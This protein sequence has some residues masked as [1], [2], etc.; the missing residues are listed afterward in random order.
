MK[1]FIGLLVL[2]FAMSFSVNAQ[3]DYDTT[4]P[5]ITNVTASPSIVD[6]SESSQI[7]TITATGT[8]DLS[9]IQSLSGFFRAPT[10]E[11][12]L[13]IYLYPETL[14]NGDIVYVGEIEVPYASSFSTAVEPGIWTFDNCTVYDNANNSIDCL[15]QDS[16]QPSFEVTYITFVLGCT[17]TT[18]FNYNAEA[19][20]DDASCVYPLTPISQNNIHSAV[21]EWVANESLAESTYGHI[22]DWDVSSVTNMNQLFT[23]LTSFNGDFSNASSFNGDISSWD[24]SS[25]TNMEYMFYIAESFNN[26]IS[27]WD[28]SSVTNMEYM[29][30]D[31]TNFNGDIS[32]WDVSSV[33]NM[34]YLFSNAISFNQDISSWNVSGL[35]SMLG[36]FNDATDFNQDLSGWDVS[37]IT[38]MN[39]MFTGAK[40]FN[41]D[42][43][44]WDVSS[45]TNMEYMFF[46]AES[47]NQDISSWNGNSDLHVTLM[48]GILTSTGLSEENKCL[49]NTSFSAL[50]SWPY[51]WSGFC[52][53]GCTNPTASNYNAN[54]NTDDASCNIPLDLPEGW[55]M[56]GYTCMESVDA[57]VG[58]SSISDKIEIVKDE[59]GLAYL[60]SWGFNAMGSLHFSEGY[61]IKMI[62]EVTNYQFCEPEY[63]YIFQT[64]DM[65]DIQ[66]SNSSS[67]NGWFRQTSIEC[68]C[69]YEWADN[70]NPS[71][72]A[73]DGSCLFP[74]CTYNWADNYSPF[75]TVNDGSCFLNG[76][77]QA[78][79]DAAFNEGVASVTECGI[80]NGLS[81]N[82]GCGCGNPQAQA[83][84]DCDGNEIVPLQ[85]GDQHAGGIVFQ[86]NEDGTGLVYNDSFIGVDP[87][88]WAWNDAMDAAESATS[89]GYDDWYLPNAP[90]LQL[91]GIVGFPD[92]HNFWSSSEYDSNHAWGVDPNDGNSYYSD[93]DNKGMVRI[94]RA[95]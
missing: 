2:V 72:N 17:D 52:I 33:T 78:D 31:A 64:C 42:I 36:M 44:S 1:N 94:I 56:F 87:Y 22:S 50:D 58:F 77:S 41:G 61:Q 37:N 67:S 70:Y 32:S 12:V 16:Y 38:N 81:I 48:E 26:D 80:L 8:D 74:G 84:Y 39:Q 19:N 88:I 69:T 21:A 83:G 63:V 27:S 75:A 35:T 24:V 73:E 25:V 28:V 9:G 20:T 3:Q 40:S 79:L 53:E 92:P 29:F 23:G 45:V 82:L 66:Y 14:E 71:A 47:F 6:V 95:F 85:I 90:E 65:Y 57:M 91:T 68:G 15:N 34:E 93:K 7:V 54:A 30:N 62:E 13:W 46:L 49:I 86:I 55:S 10:S 43:S 51:D 5:V 18:A 76:I 89:E 59:W 4:P 60:P 11:A